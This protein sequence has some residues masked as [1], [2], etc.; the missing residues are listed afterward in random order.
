MYG[1]LEGMRVVEA[2][3][4]VAAPSAGMYLSQMGAEVVRIDQIGG[5]PDFRRWPLAGEASLYWESLNQGKK[6]VAI[7]LGRP[8]GRELAAR[9]IT[10]GGP[11]GGLFLTNYPVAGFLAHERLAAVRPDLVTVRVMGR[12][13]GSPALDYTV[14]CE[15]GLPGLT[16]PVDSG[17]VNHVL[18]AWDLLSGA[19]AAFSLL[20]AERQ[21]RDTG[22]GREVRV[23]LS[24]MAI[25]SVANLGMVA[26]ALHTGRDRPRVGNDLYGAFGRDFLTA[27]GKRLMI[28]AHTPRQW[29]GLL[30]VLDIEGAVARVEAETGVSFAREEGLRFIHRDRLNPLVERAVAQRTR[31]ELVAA[32]DPLGICWG[33]Y[34]TVVEAAHDPEL[35]ADNPL[36][37]TI[38]QPSGLS[39]PVPGAPA[40]LVPDER[41]PARRAP[42]LGEHTDWALSTLAGLDSGAIGRLHD[43][44]LVA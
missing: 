35:V 14:N 43:E 30:A 22:R 1:L 24:D 11:E 18:P 33:D 28:V 8:E 37:A 34:Q 17:P 16:G 6:S 10:G 12:A 2:A 40:T 39:Y 31:A 42:R 5:G 4:F 27:D 29:S 41:Q 19:Y 21:R 13:D 3:A 15:V 32:F 44:G 23:P 26:D 9:L 20:A 25:A 7:D 38:T 36:F